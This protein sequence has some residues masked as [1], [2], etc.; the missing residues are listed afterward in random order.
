MKAGYTKDDLIAK[1]INLRLKEMWSTKS[2]LELLDSLG[3]AKT[4]SYEY[5]KLAKKELK[6]RYNETNDALIEEAIYQYEQMIEKAAI[7]G[8]LRLWNDLRKELNKIQGIYAA[9]KV[10][11]TSGG[12]KITEIR[13]VQVVK[14]KNKDE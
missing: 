8:D 12:D 14:E 7:S 4:Q 2:I 13:L 1:I 6:D 10:D 11:I 3:Y 9:D 5:I